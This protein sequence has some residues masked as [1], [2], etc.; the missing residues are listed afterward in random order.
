MNHPYAEH[1][2]WR[3][4]ALAGLLVGGISLAT[5]ADVWDCLLRVGAAFLVFAVAGLG[6]RAVLQSGTGL[7]V[8][9]G[10]HSVRKSSEHIS[11]EPGGAAAHGTDDA[12]SDSPKSDV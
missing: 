7:P 3:V 8:A 11:E 9:P 6:F 4:A 1:L 5:G 10:T 2:P 12:A